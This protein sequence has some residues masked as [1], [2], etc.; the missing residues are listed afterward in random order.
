MLFPRTSQDMLYLAKAGC[1]SQIEQEMKNKADTR[2]DI[3]L[4]HTNLRCRQIDPVPC[5]AM[6]AEYRNSF[7]WYTIFH[8]TL[9]STE[10]DA[11][12]LFSV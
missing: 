9:I 11:N 6:Q 4:R 3:E 12:R 1:S 8:K 10:Q 7:T 5:F 2:S